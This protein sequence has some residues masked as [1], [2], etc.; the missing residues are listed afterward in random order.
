MIVTII[1]TY[2]RKSNRGGYVPISF[3]PLWATMERKGVTTY[4]L[5]DKDKVVG[6]GTYN[7]LKA[8]QDVS[9]HTISILCKYLDCA[10]QDVMEF[11][12]DDS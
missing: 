1:G 6:G 5:K 2:W 8:N 7:R 12:D 3:S 11:I 10:V 4:A 9:T